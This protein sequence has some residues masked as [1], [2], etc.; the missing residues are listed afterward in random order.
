MTRSNSRA[1]RASAGWSCTRR[2]RRYQTTAVPIPE[3]FTRVDSNEMGQLAPAF[4][5]FPLPLVALPSEHVPLH[6]FE[7]RYKT[8]I[9]I[10][11]EQQREFGIVWLGDEELKSVGCAVGVERI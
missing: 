5:L 2:S 4:P 3:G 8:M 7:E 6:I 10:C 11:L 1:A 9:G